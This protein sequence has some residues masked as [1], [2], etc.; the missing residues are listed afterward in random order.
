VDAS[1]ADLEH[2]CELL[3]RIDLSPWYEAE[4]RIALARAAVRLGDTAQARELL[5]EAETHLKRSPDATVPQRWIADCQAQAEQSSATAHQEW[6]L[7]TAELRVLQFLPTHLSFPEM[8]ERLYVS[9][10]T[11]KT[12]ARSVYRKLG[13]S[14]RGE[15]VVRAREVG[16]LDQASHAGVGNAGLAGVS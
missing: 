16:L 13:A 10:N 1:Q 7:T 9:A 11:V 8:A 2:A 15:A 5:A 4:C 12:H 14:S 6:S 3:S